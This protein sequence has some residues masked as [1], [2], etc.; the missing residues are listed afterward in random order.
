LREGHAYALDSASQFRALDG[1][2]EAPF[3]QSVKDALAKQ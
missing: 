2:D 1:T 3:L